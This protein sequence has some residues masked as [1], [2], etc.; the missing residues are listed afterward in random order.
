MFR[1][2]NFKMK[3]RKTTKWWDC[4][5]CSYM[6]RTL[7]SDRLMDVYSFD[8][9]LTMINGTYGTVVI[10]T[11]IQEICIHSYEKHMKWKHSNMNV[12]IPW[13]VIEIEFILCTSEILPSIVYSLERSWNQQKILTVIIFPF[14]AFLSSHII[15]ATLYLRKQEQH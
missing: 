11:R 13:T 15:K 7:S 5:K 1:T 12:N 6:Q 2:A 4:F 3:S 8:L 14:I 9:L 10:D